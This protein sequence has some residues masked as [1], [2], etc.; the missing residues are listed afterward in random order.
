MLTQTINKFELGG[1]KILH[2]GFEEKLYIYHKEED[3]E[4]S[5]FINFD[6]I[7]LSVNSSKDKSSFVLNDDF[8]EDAKSKPSFTKFIIEDNKIKIESSGP[9]NKNKNKTITSV[10]YG[11]DVINFISDMLY[12]YMFL[13]EN[14]YR[15]CT[16]DV[17]R[18]SLRKR[19]DKITKFM[20]K[21]FS[22]ES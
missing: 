15:T 9:D 5:I 16:D 11:Y 19:F 1:F 6:N 13:L 14:Q 8:V 12:K 2:F 17:L 21:G 10:F 7:I 18:K 22:F 4:Q 20:S 3:F